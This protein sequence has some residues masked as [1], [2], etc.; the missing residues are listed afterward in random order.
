VDQTT[1]YFSLNGELEVYTDDLEE[2]EHTAVLYLMSCLP[3]AE[4]A[5]QRDLQVEIWDAEQPE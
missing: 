2:A 5:L 3:E 1:I 4:Q